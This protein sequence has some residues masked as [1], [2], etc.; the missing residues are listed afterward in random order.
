MKYLC[1]TR[2]VIEMNKKRQQFDR[3]L[4]IKEE[5][6]NRFEE[7]FIFNKIFPLLFI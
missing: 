2:E 1:K 5:Q 7:F 4:V 3:K 6:Q